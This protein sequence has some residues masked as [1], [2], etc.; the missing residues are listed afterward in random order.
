MVPSLEE[1]LRGN[2]SIADFRSIDMN[3][4]LGRTPITGPA[5][6]AEL[7][8]YRGKRILVTGAGG[9]IGSELALQLSKLTHSHCR[10]LT[11][12]KTG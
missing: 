4:L 2:S 5:T 1:V 11:K 10:C 7:A 8:A 9:S 3:D 12:T 6:N